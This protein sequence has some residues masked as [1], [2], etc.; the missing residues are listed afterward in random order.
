[1]NFLQNVVVAE[2][3]KS[4]MGYFRGTPDYN[5][6]QDYCVKKCLS[7]WWRVDT[8]TGT[9]MLCH[10]EDRRC[11]L[12]VANPTLT[13]LRSLDLQ[14]DNKYNRDFDSQFDRAVFITEDEQVDESNIVNYLEKRYSETGLIIQ[15]KHDNKLMITKRD[16]SPDREWCECPYSEFCI[17]VEKDG[18]IKVIILC[19]S[20]EIVEYYGFYQEEF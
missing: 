14:E 3:E 15:D 9:R 20:I 7:G 4:I 5:E 1:M 11:D 13:F 12:I 16:D 17:A 8:L 19:P 2:D 6:N 18:R 10:F